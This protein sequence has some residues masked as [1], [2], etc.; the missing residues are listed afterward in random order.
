M[1]FKNAIK[2]VTVL[3]LSTMVG[4]AFA[5]GI[6]DVGEAVDDSVITTKVKAAFADQSM[7]SPLDIHV[8]TKHGVVTLK[9][10]VDTANQY[11]RAISVT[12]SV[13]GVKDVDSKKLKWKS[14]L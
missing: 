2:H 10:K 4:T 5:S 6:K 8:K 11:Q 9:G 1:K 14:I 13:E 12:K 7:L 3:A